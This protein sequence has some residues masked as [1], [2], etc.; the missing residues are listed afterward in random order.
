[1]IG[2]IRKTFHGVSG[3]RSGYGLGYAFSVSSDFGKRFEAGL[4]ARVSQQPR[5]RWVSSEDLLKIRVR[6]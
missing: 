6:E 1:M 3:R 5:S 4:K 2:S